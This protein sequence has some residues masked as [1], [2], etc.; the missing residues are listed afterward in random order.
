VS[1]RVASLAL[2][3]L[4]GCSS[5]S[6]RV[7]LVQSCRELRADSQSAAKPRQSGGLWSDEQARRFYVC[8]AIGIGARDAVW[9]AEG[10]SAE[11]RAHLA[12]E[13]RRAARRTARQ[14]MSNSSSVEELRERDRKKYGNPDGPT[15]EY[16]MERARANGLQ[17]DARFESIVQSAQQT[18]PATDRRFGLLR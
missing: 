5:G 9:R 2:L 14:M 16:L 6:D 18:D 17:G 7:E 1:R 13:T 15:F 12:F 8:E 3:L 4:L 10:R 11:E